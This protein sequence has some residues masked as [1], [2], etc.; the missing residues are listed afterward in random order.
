MQVK[1]YTR[2]FIRDGAVFIAIALSILLTAPGFATGIPLPENGKERRDSVDNRDTLTPGSRPII[3][4]DSIPGTPRDSTAADSSA[5]KPPFDDIVSYHWTDSTHL[6]VL[7]KKVYLYGNG[8]NVKY[9]TTEVTANYIEM[10]MNLKTAMATG[11]PDSTGALVGTPKF[12]DGAQEFDSKELRY[13]FAT[14]KAFIKNIITQQGEGYMQGVFTKKQNDSIYCVLDGWYTTCDNHDHPHFMLRMNKAKLIKDR[15]VFA[16]TSYLVIEDIPT[17]IGVPFIFFPITDKGTSGIII[18]TYG[19]ERMRGFNLR[20]GGYYFKFN[21]YFDLTLTGDIYSN[22][23]W[24]LQ[25]QSQY[26]LRYKFRG[27]FNFSTSKNHTGEKGLPDYQESSDWSLQWTHSQD[28]KAN[29]YSSFSASVNISSAKNNYYNAT[30]LNDIAD[31]RKQSSVTWSK[32]WPDSP[33]SLNGSFNHNQNARDTSISLTLPNLSLRMTQIYPFR[34]KGKSSNL[35]WY[36][37]IGVSY[38]GEFRNSISTKEYKL[39]KSSFSQ[40]WNNG[41]KHDI[42]LSFS[43]K[44]AKDITFSPTISYSGFLNLKYLEKIWV[45]DTSARGGV[46][47]KRYI[48][49]ITY[50][51]QYST[52][53]SIGYTPT[54]Y[55]MYTFKPESNIIAIRHMVRPSFSIS[56]RPKIGPLGTYAKTYWDGEKHV[57]YSM[58]EGLTFAPGYIATPQSGSLSF[59]IDNNIEMKLRENARDTTGS[60]EPRKVK[61]LESFNLSSGYDMFRDSMKFNNISLSARTKII[62]DKI[63]VNLNGSIDPY[64]LDSTGRRINKYAGGLGRLTSLGL[65]SGFSFSADNGKNKEKKN[66]LVHGLYDQYVDFD[67]PWSINVNYRANY[68]NPGA[69]KSTITQSIDVSGSLALTS[70]WQLSYSTGFD[71]TNK[72]FAATSF[73]VTRDLHCWEMTFNCIPFGQHQSYNFRINVRSSMLRDLK[74]TK[75]ESWYDR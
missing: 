21:D 14:K 19:E 26:V 75:R 12:K 35:K 40:D 47:V 72:Q 39:M 31:Q 30:S 27:N 23:S 28:A 44:I 69:G 15:K 24:R 71:I 37:N 65:T 16:T 70:K 52:G 53:A 49:K 6:S 34:A 50:S 55:G 48:E 41:Y 22:G 46:E 2:G 18:P 54:I 29:P 61:I 63:D 42:P 45:P 60:G 57:Q 56:Y 25:T 1:I 62:N 5:Q 10:D 11:T 8:S 9:L 64:A 66:E 32:K 20:N 51:H 7:E 3:P 17:V 73:D 38:S 67:L 36:D 13:N 43:F 68:S 59:S 4:L 58:Y 74:L 33:F